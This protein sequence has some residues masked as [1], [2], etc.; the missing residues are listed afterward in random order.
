MQATQLVARHKAGRDAGCLPGATGGPAD[1]TAGQ[2]HTCTL[3]KAACQ[4]QPAMHQLPTIREGPWQ[5]LAAWACSVAVLR[6]CFAL[7]LDVTRR[8]PVRSATDIAQTSKQC[9]P[10]DSKQ[11]QKVLHLGCSRTRVALLVQQWM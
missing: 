9:W 7:A 3:H 5:A 8:D 4:Y 1:L 11:Q 6:T 2:Q 10:Q